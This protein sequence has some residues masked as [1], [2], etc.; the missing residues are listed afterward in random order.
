MLSLQAQER[1]Q[2]LEALRQRYVLRRTKDII[3]D[4]L[5]MKTDNIVFCCLAEAQYR[6][7]K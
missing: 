4:Q 6:A 3:K 7:Y 5:P 1:R 2:R